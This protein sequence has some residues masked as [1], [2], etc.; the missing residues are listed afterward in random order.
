M[1]KTINGWIGTNIH[2]FDTNKN[3]IELY[4][5][6]LFEHVEAAD[7]LKYTVCH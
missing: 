3:K 1:W 2:L 4:I 5:L 6:T 7:I